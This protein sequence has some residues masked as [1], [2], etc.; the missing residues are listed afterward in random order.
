MERFTRLPSAVLFRLGLITCC[1]A[2]LAGLMLIMLGMPHAG[3]AQGSTA[4]IA[5]FATHTPTP[6]RKPSPT[7]TSTPN[8]T[9]TSTPKPTATSTP[10]PA[11]TATS[12]PA[13]TA[14][15]RPAA[16]ATRPAPT[17]TIAFTLGVTTSATPGA[18]PSS[19]A[20]AT[21]TPGRSKGALG[22]VPSWL[23]GGLV[24]VFVIL[25]AF[26]LI[27]F[28][29]AMRSARAERRGR[30]TFTVAPPRRPSGQVARLTQIPPERKQPLSREQMLALR[31]SQQ[32]AAPS[33]VLEHSTAS[34]AAIRVV[35]GVPVSLPITEAETAQLPVARRSAVGKIVESTTAR[36]RAVRPNSALPP[37][38][39]RQAPQER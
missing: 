1:G 22:K 17:A 2:L 13:P 4:G 34:L 36:L 30:P 25:L 15:S 32:L 37:P 14:T 35:D 16:T 6:T 26:S 8:P 28:P 31:E 18:A 19:T 38:A 39:Q 3:Q 7:A 27:I 5:S 23:A 21:A 24:G 20:P 12:K 29:L 9:A 33:G 11:P 10:K